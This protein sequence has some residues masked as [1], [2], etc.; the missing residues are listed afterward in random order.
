MA[1]VCLPDVPWFAMTTKERVG[2]LK[3]SLQSVAK[4]A[5]AGT[6]DEYEREVREIYGLLREA[7]EIALGEVLLNGAVERYRP[8]IETRRAR[9]LHDITKK[10]LDVLEAEMTEASR[11]IRGHAAAAADGTP[12]PVPDEVKQRVDAFEVWFKAINAR[13]S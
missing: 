11:W 4:T 6:P 12:L 9:K 10:D 8:S 7:W 5:K 2:Y 3:H 13:R 1:G